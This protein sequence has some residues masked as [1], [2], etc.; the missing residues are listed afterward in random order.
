MTLPAD[1]AILN[2]FSLIFKQFKLLVLIT[3]VTGALA[4]RKI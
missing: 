4:M 1:Y 2:D 3:V